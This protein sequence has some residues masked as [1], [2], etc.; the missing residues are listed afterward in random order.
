MGAHTTRDTPAQ[1]SIEGFQSAIIRLVALSCATVVALAACGNPAPT[2]TQVPPVTEIASPE[3]PA[4]PLPR[5]T[6]SPTGTATAVIPSVT[7]VS[8]SPTPS[9]SEAPSGELS[10]GELLEVVKP[11]IVSIIRFFGINGTGFLVEGNYIVTAAHVVW[12]LTVVDVKFEDGTEYE[13]VPVAAIDHF[14]DLAFLGPIDTSG[15]HLQ[16]GNARAEN[17]GNTMYSVGHAQG[18]KE[19]F[20]TKGEFVRLED[21]KDAFISEVTTSAEG[22]GGMSGGPVANGSGEVIGVNLRSGERREHR[23]FLLHRIPT[24]WT[25]Y[26]AARMPRHSGRDSL[27]RTEA[28]EGARVSSGRPLGYCGVLG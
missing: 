16:L 4:T 22:I 5:P 27:L 7:P 1:S 21:W 18:S 2:P 28:S 25:G 8:P 17:E 6:P 3:T 20:A 26:C 11:S 14:A 10:L 15:P 24:A 19:L 9:T 12:P 23:S 13:D